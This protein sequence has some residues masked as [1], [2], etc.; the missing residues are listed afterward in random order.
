MA[1]KTTTPK[2]QLLASKPVRVLR[3]G[4]PI[5]ARQQARFPLAWTAKLV[6]QAKI[7][8]ESGNFQLLGD[9][10]EDLLGGDDRHHGTLASVAQN[11]L[12]LPLSFN[13]DGDRRRKSR[14]ETAIEEDF[15]ELAPLAE[16]VD[17]V[18]QGLS[19]G[20]AVGQLT[21]WK[22]SRRGGRWLPRVQPIETRCVRHEPRTGEWFV[23]TDGGELK[24][25]PGDGQWILFTPYG[26][27]RPWIRGTWRAC[28]LWALLKQYAM[29]DWARNGENAAGIK[30]VETPEGAK[31]SDRKEAAEALAEIGADG[32]FVPMPKWKMELI[33]QTANTYQTYEKQIEVSNKAIAVANKGESHTSGDQASGM[34]DSAGKTRKEVSDEKSAFVAKALELFFYEQL[35]RPWTNIN[36]GGAA[37]IPWPCYQTEE[38]E[39]LSQKAAT[40]TAAAGAVKSLREQRINVSVE[41]VVEEFNIPIKEGA[42]VEIE[43]EESPIPSNEGNH[44][45]TNPQ[46]DPKAPPQEAASNEG[47]PPAAQDTEQ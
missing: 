12:K 15:S 20:F 38:Q 33:Q 47:N 8:A 13:A 37:Q 36:F 30:T 11:A 28:S 31:D 43:P 10:Y 42:P 35:L 2:K 14:L 16:L 5:V 19:I 17:L 3:G 41:E 24:I 22:E 21:P 40:W 46:E 39:D 34:G 27:N 32:V 4:K 9:L 18:S 25:T 26:S 29:K 6:R 44:P 7:Q 45:P 23:M 1:A